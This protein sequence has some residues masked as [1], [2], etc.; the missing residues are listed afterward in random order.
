MKFVLEHMLPRR[1]RYAKVVFE[2][3]GASLSLRIDGSK[4][5]WHASIGTRKPVEMTDREYSRI[6][7]SDGVVRSLDDDGETVI[8]RSTSGYEEVWRRP[9]WV[10]EGVRK[11]RADG[12]GG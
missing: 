5:D 1:L 2:A 8:V 9:R 3:G 6:R 10:L 12:V 7:S 4:A 11:A